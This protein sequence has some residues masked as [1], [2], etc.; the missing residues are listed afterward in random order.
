VPHP[1]GDIDVRL[2]RSEDGR[3][4]AEVTLPPGLDGLDGV[5]VWRGREVS[6]APGRQDR[7]F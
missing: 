1:L 3:L 4:R 6:L 2:T 7:E 5:L